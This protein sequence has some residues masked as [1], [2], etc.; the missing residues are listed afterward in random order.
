ML[1]FLA[2]NIFS[3]P[4]DVRSLRPRNGLAVKRSVFKTTGSEA[5]ATTRQRRNV[6]DPFV[7]LAVHCFMANNASTLF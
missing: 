5:A 4:T 3:E 7:Y 2:Y 6:Q 1:P